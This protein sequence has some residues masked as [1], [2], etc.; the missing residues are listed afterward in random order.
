VNQTNIL[1]TDSMVVIGNEI[2]IW[3]A[4][5]VGLFLFHSLLNVVMKRGSST[6]GESEDS[7]QYR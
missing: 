3:T 1:G 5:L 6:R 7:L 2:L 4:V